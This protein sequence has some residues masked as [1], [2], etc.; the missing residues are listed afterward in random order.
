VKPVLIIFA[1]APWR[2]GRTRDGLELAL[3]LLAFDHPLGVLFV[4]DGVQLLVPGQNPGPSGL[5]EVVR[6]LHALPHHGAAA[7]VASA[8]CLRRR[9]I[10][11]TG[12]PVARL[13]TAAL[14]QFIK[15]FGHVHCC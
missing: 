10:T 5:A 6:G 14:G 12:L 8:A 2:G 1:S 13:E 3:A 9:G 15:G 7:M 4:E 11:D